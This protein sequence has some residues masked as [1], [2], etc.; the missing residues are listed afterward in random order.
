MENIKIK[1]LGAH[2]GQFVGDKVLANNEEWSIPVSNRGGILSIS[3][4]ETGYTFVYAIA[5]SFRENFAQQMNSWSNNEFTIHR[6]YLDSRTIII[7][8]ICGESREFMYKWI[9]GW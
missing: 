2:L 1:V 6:S 5:Y 9:L 3:S 4:E 7:K 8:N